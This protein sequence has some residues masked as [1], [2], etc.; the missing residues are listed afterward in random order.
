MNTYMSISMYPEYAFVHV[1]VK[2]EDG[3]EFSMCEQVSKEKALELA[4]QFN[5]QIK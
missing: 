1:H 3:Y 2:N 4:W 5:I